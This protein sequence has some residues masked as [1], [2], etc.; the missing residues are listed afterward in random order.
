MAEAGWL[1]PG[2]VR[3]P[4]CPRL[5]DGDDRGG[6]GLGRS[7]SPTGTGT[8]VGPR[9]MTAARGFAR[10]LAGIDPAP[11]SPRWG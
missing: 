11:R 1:L 3:L 2:F 4:R 6:S 9:R 10:Y 7:N 5:P 8:S